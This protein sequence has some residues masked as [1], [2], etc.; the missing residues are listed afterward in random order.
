MKSGFSS[1]ILIFLSSLGILAY[2]LLSSSASFKEELF[3]TLYPKP[4]SKAIGKAESVADEVIVK[5]KEGTDEGKKDNIRRKHNLSKVGIIP[6]IEVERLKVAPPLKEAT[7]EQLKNDPNVLFAEPNYLVYPAVLKGPAKIEPNDPNLATQWGMF[8][9]RAADTDTENPGA[10]SVTK[11]SRSVKIAILDT[12]IDERHEDLKRHV[13]S[14]VNFADSPTTDDICGH[15]TAVAGVAGALTDNRRGIASVGYDTSLMNVKVLG[16]GDGEGRCLA[17]TAR[18]ANG[19]VSAVDNGAKVINMSLSHPVESALE[20]VAIDYAFSQGAVLIAAAGN[21]NTSD[22][23]YPAFYDNVISVAATDSND[24]K[25]GFSN[26]GTSVDVAAPGSNIYSTKKGNSYDYFSGTSIAAPSVSGLA[27][28]IWAK[29]DCV[30]NTC[31]INQIQSTSDPIAGTGSLWVWGRV[32]AYRA[33]TQTPPIIKPSPPPIQPADTA[34]DTFTRA[35]NPESLGTTEVGGKTWTTLSGRWGID[36]NQAYTSDSCQDIIPGYSVVDW[37]KSDGI[38]QVK[39][40]TNPQGTRIP[41]RLSDTDNLYYVLTEPRFPG[42]VPAYGLW[43]K[44]KPQGQPFALE[45][46]L[47]RSS[48]ITP[49][50]GD[51]IKLQLNG[52]SIKVYA[53]GNLII[54]VSD[55]ALSGTKY[56]L[57]YFACGSPVSHFDDFLITP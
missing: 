43:K 48:G 36:N 4:S 51:I 28:L 46:F 55:N 30:T 23:T 16:D 33:V 50:D 9:I 37:G 7:I 5:F 8:K 2:I 54:D 11:G 41:F 12:G 38:L 31:V 15:G 20:E 57:G 22:P 47:T 32:N 18:V 53:N 56:G 34:S 40:T 39:L 6:K 35:N 10:W 29:G 25:A 27:A 26:Y 14:S 1:V 13:V 3:G 19:I 24:Q 49:A 45:T 21:E 44:V 52:S 42:D 17:D